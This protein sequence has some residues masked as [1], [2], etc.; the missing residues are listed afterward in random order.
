M[1]NGAILMGC[2]VLTHI[3]FIPLCCPDQHMQICTIHI[4]ICRYVNGKVPVVTGCIVWQFVCVICYTTVLTSY[5]VLPPSSLLVRLQF[6][7]TV[8]YTAILTCYNASPPSS[9]VWVGTIHY[10]A[11]LTCYNAL[12]PSSLLVG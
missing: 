11:I 7:G 8:H 2:I 9:V 1:Q 4:A 6:V 3:Q 10:T 5:T 12:P